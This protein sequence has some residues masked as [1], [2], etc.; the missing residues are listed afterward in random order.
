MQR[1]ANVS[2]NAKYYNKPDKTGLTKANTI[3]FTAH[4]KS[5]HVLYTSKF[6]DRS[7]PI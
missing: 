1:N 6:I 5:F 7:K 2:K 4:V 3:P